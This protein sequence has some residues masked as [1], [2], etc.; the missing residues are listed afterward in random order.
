[1]KRYLSWIVL[2]LAAVVFAGTH[3]SWMQSLP[4]RVA[5]HFDA[6]G[7]VNG[8]MSRSTHNAFM[9]LFGL[10]LPSF[11]MALMWVM[12]FLPPN[13]MNVPNAA[14][15]RSPEHYPTA[16]KFMQE[17]SRWFAACELLWITL[18]NHQIVAANLTKPP[19]LATA[20]MLWLTG[21]FLIVVGASIVW[22][23]RHFSR[24]PEATTPASP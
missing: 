9:L 17:W 8:W 4:E 6:S 14:Y 18:L 20:P 16:M 12:R 24:T 23:I 15:W 1:M 7:K 22:M 3:L 19:H 5:T 10:G 2:L 11:I 13:L 21:V